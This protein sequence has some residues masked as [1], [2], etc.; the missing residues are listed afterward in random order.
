MEGLWRF[1]PWMARA[2]LL[3]VALLFTLIGLRYL[4]DPVGNAAA[5]GI[6]LGSVE[7]ISRLRVAFGAFPLGFA[8]VLL[9]CLVSKERLLRGLVVLAALIGVVT[10]V[11]ALGIMID[12][13]AAETV[14][15]LRVEAIVLTLSL[16]GIFLEL[17]RRRGLHP[18]R[19][20]RQ[21]GAAS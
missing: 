1:A 17:A 13:P 12:G 11:R 7:A 5:D 9:G 6:A 10:A 20:A 8:A 15:L 14:K 19:A 4:T 21:T 16:I 18:M 2:L 3:A